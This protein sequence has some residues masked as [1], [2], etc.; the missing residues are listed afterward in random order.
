[1]VFSGN[2]NPELA[3]GICRC[4]GISLGNM[5]VGHFPDY[6]FDPRVNEHVAGRDA[7]IVQPTHATP[8]SAFDNVGELLLMVHTLKESNAGRV[9]AVIPYY[10]YARS[11]WQDEPRKPIVAK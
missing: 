8:Q 10:G 4:L 6:E 3:R 11:D 7:F 9:T 5:T 1:M 2:G